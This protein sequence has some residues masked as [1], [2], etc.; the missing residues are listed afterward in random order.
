MFNISSM[1][2][3]FIKD[4]C[5]SDL[6]IINLYGS[7]YSFKTDLSKKIGQNIDNISLQ[8][9]G[10]ILENNKTFKSYNIKEKE[11][12]DLSLKNN[13]GT[14][15]KGLLI[16]LSILILFTFIISMLSGLL[17]ITAHLI[18]AAIITAFSSLGNL[19]L[20]L[21]SDKW[22]IKNFFTKWGYK[23]FNIAKFFL[24]N[25][26]IL[27][28]VIII[29]ALSAYIPYYLKFG[30]NVCK[31]INTSFL[32]G[33]I[34][35]I[36]YSA[37]YL[38]YNIPYIILNLIGDSSGK[39][40]QLI[41]KGLKKLVIL[42]RKIGLFFAWPLNNVYISILDMLEI[43]FDKATEAENWMQQ[44]IFNFE[45]LKTLETTPPY[46][47][48]IRRVQVLW[49]M[50][51][52]TYMKPDEKEQQDFSRSKIMLSY[53]ARFVIDNILGLVILLFSSL[54]TI[55]P[56]NTAGDYNRQIEQKGKIEN[57]QTELLEKLLQK[58]TKEDRKKI[59]K[60]SNSK[61]SEK[62]SNLKLSDLIQTLTKNLKA[63][64]KNQK[65]QKKILK[66]QIQVFQRYQNVKSK[67]EWTKG[68]ITKFTKKKEEEVNTEVINTTCIMNYIT[69]GMLSGAPFTVLLWLIL[70]IVLLI[71]PD[72][73]KNVGK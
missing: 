2:Y 28:F 1:V 51:K 55:C 8:Y 33:A 57:K 25:L 58:M 59:E 70:F 19:I 35:G 20:R 53:V 22:P 56:S 62:E 13:G 30:N 60:A 3:I 50:Y 6:H 36:Y 11:T 49:D 4:N 65:K 48:Y 10:K 34:I 24:S 37:M 32:L 12:I 67:M 47:V 44:F 66:G 72:I 42:S 40:A 43:G 71:K 46:N 73:F 69:N 21:I 9:H 29:T 39:L 68:Q 38:I 23:L 17:P 63:T 16:F 27:V 52:Y 15:S 45:Q 41:M 54:K 64:P 18:S 5:K 7:I 26:S 14:V 31:A 61:L